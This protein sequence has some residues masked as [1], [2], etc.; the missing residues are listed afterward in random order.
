MVPVFWKAKQDIYVY[1]ITLQVVVTVLSKLSKPLLPGILDNVYLLF[2]YIHLIQKL[3]E[4]NEYINC[5]K[6]E[7]TSDELNDDIRLSIR[8]LENLFN[9]SYNYFA[10][11]FS[12]EKL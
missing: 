6:K 8:T 5:L 7:L 2:S 1:I 9:Q 3:T 12:Q 4:I 11:I 10:C